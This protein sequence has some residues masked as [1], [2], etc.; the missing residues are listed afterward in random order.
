MLR[1]FELL[2]LGRLFPDYARAQ[3]NV[4]PCSIQNVHEE[5]T[6]ETW[7][8]LDFEDSDHIVMLGTNW[9]TS[10]FE[11]RARQHSKRGGQVSQVIY[12]LIPYRYPQYCIDS[13]TKSLISS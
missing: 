1:K 6:I 12:D 4:S 7:S 8:L 2:T 11:K 3:M 9:N 13:L 5:K 10:A